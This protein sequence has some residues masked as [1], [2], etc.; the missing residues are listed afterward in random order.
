[1]PA[2]SICAVDGCDKLRERRQWCIA[3][4]KRW[5]RHGDP[6]AGGTPQRTGFTLDE[7]LDHELARARRDDNG[8]LI[9]QCCIGAQGY[10]VI[11]RGRKRYTV[12]RLILQ[13]KLRRKLSQKEVTRHTCDV[14]ACIEPE[15]LIPGTQADNT[16]D[17][18]KRGRHNPAC[19]Y[20]ED[21]G[22][23][24]L[25]EEEVIEM[26]NRYADSPVLGMKKK[27]AEEYGVSQTT[28]GRIINE[29]GWRHLLEPD[30]L[31]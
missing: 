1:M 2:Q 24:K 27:L 11:S 3:H 23:S 19:A 4:Y 10:A 29:K 22:S 31:F 9:A 20:G 12:P 30:D 17:M 7:I 15:H 8:C 28:A 13:R 18:M 26:R 6:L 21:Q 16:D 25:T 14:R 5:K